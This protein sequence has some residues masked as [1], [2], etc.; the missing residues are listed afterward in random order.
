MVGHFDVVLVYDV[1]SAM[2]LVVVSYE[3]LKILYTSPNK[4]YFCVGSV[5]DGL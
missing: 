5:D 1:V 3:V 4:C 2:Q